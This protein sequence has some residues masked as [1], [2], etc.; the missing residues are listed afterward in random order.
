MGALLRN[1]LMKLPSDIVTAVRGKGLL[2]AIVIRETKGAA[3]RATLARGAL[4]PFSFHESSPR[5]L[6]WEGGGRRRGKGRRDIC[7]RRLLAATQ[8]VPLTRSDP[9]PFGVRADALA[10][11]HAA[12]RKALSSQEE[13]TCGILSGVWVPLRWLPGRL[14]PGSFRLRVT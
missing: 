12:G 2:N 8:Y 4:F 1:E 13:P 10:A 14:V 9:G 5:V 7:E 11:E 6:A 3:C